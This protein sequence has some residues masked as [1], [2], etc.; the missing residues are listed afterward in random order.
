M[1]QVFFTAKTQ[2]RKEGAKDDGVE[3]MKGVRGLNSSPGKGAEREASPQ[4]LKIS[5]Q[6]QPILQLS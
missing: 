2:G 6:P 1:Y 3:E 4:L 5:I